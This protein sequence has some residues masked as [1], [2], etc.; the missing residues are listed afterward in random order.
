MSSVGG[1]STGKSEY[2]PEPARDQFITA[3]NESRQF[4]PLARRR[5]PEPGAAGVNGGHGGPG[6]HGPDGGL[7]KSL[8]QS[9]DMSNMLRHIKQIEGKLNAKEKQLLDA[10]Q[11]VESLVHEEVDGLVRDKGREVQ[12]LVQARHGEA[13]AELG[14]GELRVS[15]DGRRVRAPP[16]SGPRQVNRSKK[17]Q[18]KSKAEEGLEDE[19]PNIDVNSSGRPQAK[20]VVEARCRGN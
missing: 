19:A 5:E 20:R 18:G 3:R 10:Q 8:M 13:R 6:G 7:A 2:A 9:D 1:P 12:G 4:I 11:N 15:D 14:G 17:E 16:A